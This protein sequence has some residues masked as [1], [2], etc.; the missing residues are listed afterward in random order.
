KDFGGF[1]GKISY[2]NKQLGGKP[3]PMATIGK[4]GDAYLQRFQ[5]LEIPT[6]CVRLYAELYTASAWIMTDRDNNQ[7]TAFYPG[8][9]CR[10]GELPIPEHSGITLAIL[11]P[12]DK[13]ATLR[14]AEK[15]VQLN[16]PFV[17]DPGQA[18]PSFSAEELRTLIAQAHWIVVNDYEGQLLS[19]VT[20]WSLM[21]ISQQVKSLVVT[22]GGDGCRVWEEGLITHIPAVKPPSVVDPTGC[23][24]AWRGGFLYGLERGW[25]IHKSARLANRMGSYKVAQS[26]PQNYQINLAQVFQGL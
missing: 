15:L 22:L 6:D 5:A 3:L 13:L 1:A 12:N 21:E 14:N 8:A 16:I 11:A 9:M 10:A 7:I 17:F 26:G 23:G 18:L 25:D 19:E 2:G 20:N 4:D 24:D